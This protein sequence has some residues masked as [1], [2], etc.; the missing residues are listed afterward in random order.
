M[1]LAILAVAIPM[2]GLP[3][4]GLVYKAAHAPKEIVVYKDKI[5]YKEPGGACMLRNERG[6]VQTVDAETFS[7]PEK[8]DP[9]AIQIDTH[10]SFGMNDGTTRICSWD[11]LDLTNVLVKGMSITAANGK[12]IM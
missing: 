5:V 3:T 1:T 12:R 4:A 8:D 11:H 10:V 7:A 9:K 2:A 6:T